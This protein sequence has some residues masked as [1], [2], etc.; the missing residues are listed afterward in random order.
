MGPEEFRRLAKSLPEAVEKEHMQ[1]PDFRVG[2]KIFATLGYPDEHWAML[3]LSPQK[4]AELVRSHPDVFSPCN[5]TW[6]LRGST[7]V[8]LKAATKPVIREAL[9]AAWRNTAPKKLVK[10]VEGD[11]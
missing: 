6:G 3:K 4:Q 10:Q 5:G 9:A 8:R 7:S 11:R 2:G 1:H